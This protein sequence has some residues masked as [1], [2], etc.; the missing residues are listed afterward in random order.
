MKI[1]LLFIERNNKIKRIYVKV[2]GDFME[3]YIQ[4]LKQQDKSENTI[5]KYTGDLKEF[6]FWFEETT[7][8]S[9]KENPTIVSTLEIQD[10]KSFLINNAKTK[11][12]NRLKISTV[13][14]KIEAIRSFFFFLE[15]IKLISNNPASKIKQIKV[16][17]KP[18]PKWLDRIEKNRLLNFIE[19][20]KSLHK[21][22]WRYYRNLTIVNVMLLAGLRR[23]E[24]VALKLDD[25]EKGYIFVRNG[26]GGKA[27]SIPLITDLQALISKWIAVR[28]EKND[29]VTDYLFTSQKGGKL[30]ISGINN[31][32]ET[33]R[34]NTGLN[35]LTPHT[36]RH[37]F[38]HDLL[39]RGATLTQVADLAGHDDLDTT[40]LYVTS[41]NRELKST[42]EL[43][44]TGKYNL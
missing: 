34:K 19:D 26:K 29:V 24:V 9:I 12:G 30:S 4:W 21:N 27:R 36:L 35:E 32:F 13:N 31:L 25:I 43:L 7:G 17:N 40:R 33:I 5:K 16:Q 44:Q 22:E 6:S 38:C 18:E 3:Q 37:T 10:W 15:D 23:S 11:G 1:N 42:I 41:S 8:K 28:N 39:E 20:E 2:N 14:S